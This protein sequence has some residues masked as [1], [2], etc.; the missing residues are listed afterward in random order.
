[1][2]PWFQL[3]GHQRRVGAT[4][5]HLLMF[6]HAQSLPQLVPA[7]GFSLKLGRHLFY[8]FFYHRGRWT[9]EPGSEPTFSDDKSLVSSELVLFARLRLR[10]RLSLA[11][12][13]SRRLRTESNFLLVLG[14][15]SGEASSGL[16]SFSSSG[17]LPTSNI[18]LTK[19]IREKIR[20]FLIL[21][22]GN[23]DKMDVIN[24]FMFAHNEKLFSKCRNKGLQ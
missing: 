9:G 12:A 2:P 10:L 7:A 6:W 24:Y 11:R 1:M 21:L 14:V 3:P 4:L 22:K 17:G 18:S 16:E 8:L 13:R 20:F 23:V 5:R 19:S 15:R